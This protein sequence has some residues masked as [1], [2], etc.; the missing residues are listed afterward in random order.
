MRYRDPKFSL[1]FSM[2]I[3][4]LVLVW[5]AAGFG[6]ES[7]TVTIFF[8]PQQLRFERQHGFDLVRLDGAPST[9]RPGEPALP[10]Q[11][12]HI[13]IS[14]G[15]VARSVTVRPVESYELPGTYRLLPGQ[16]PH[17]LDDRPGPP[18]MEPDDAVYTSTAPYPTQLGRLVRQTDLAG[19]Q[20]AVISLFPL[21][22]IPAT[23]RLI[24]HREL[25][26]TVETHPGHVSRERYARFTELQRRVYGDMVRKMVVNPADVRI[27]PPRTETSKSLPAGQF[28]HVIITHSAYASYF[29][30][31]IEWH[32]RRGLR[33][34]VVTTGWIDA[35]YTGD[36]TTRVR[37]FIIDAHS[38]WGTIYFLLGGEE[39]VIPFCYRQ[40]IK[41]GD[42]PDTPPSDNW[43]ADYDD[44]WT[45]E[46]MVGRISAANALEF[47]RIIAKLLK[48]EQ[49]PPMDDYILEALFVGMDYNPT[50]F[51][52]DM[53]EEV[54][55]D[56]P[57]RFTIN[58]VYDSHSGNHLDTVLVHLN[59]G[60]HL[61]NHAD[62]C[63]WWAMGAGAIN[64]GW[65]LERPHVNALT[66][67][68]RF[69][70]VVAEGCW[71]AAMPESDC[72]A[73]HFLF[74][75]VNGGG[76]S[77]CGNTRVG[78]SNATQSMGSSA[79]ERGWWKSL[80]VE[81]L[82]H[83][84]EMVAW[85]KH[86]H[87]Q[88]LTPGDSIWKHCE[89]QFVIAGD[90]AMPLWT[91]TPE[92]FEVA[93]PGT[94]PGG[95]SSFTVHVASGGSDLDSAYVCLWKSGEVYLTGYTDASGQVAFTPVPATAGSLHVTVAKHN[96]LPYRG[97]AQVT[98]S[99][100]PPVTDLSIQ[101]CEDDLVL[102]WTAPGIKTI[103]RYV[104]YRDTDGDFV[105]AEEDSI[106]GTAGTSY[107][108]TGVVGGP[109]TG[110]YYVVKAVSD[111]GGK[112]EPSNC[113][114]ELDVEL[115]TR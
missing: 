105:P 57:P 47:N 78:W 101:L 112:S 41:D 28:D 12:L 49:D 67:T 36:D 24:L 69:S 63:N 3:V 73:E 48:Y 72:M 15:H 66:N 23:G 93:H 13:A 82:Y 4:T 94:L 6:A 90:P 22:Y 20:M 26:I 60:Q 102:A 39:N 33:D 14:A 17:P 11:Q 113:V 84:G 29:D 81:D 76:V 21:Q 58:K 88:D 79:M 83:L 62:H 68:D 111:S 34:T 108:D 89:W 77:F 46:V 38:T 85:A 110:Y 50:M 80:L 51:G 35:N 42:Y 53:K 71:S 32:N 59:A 115:F 9:G 114:G 56:V 44:D 74:H 104:I 5:S 16:P 55:L 27:N 107:I 100:P 19:Q 92:S 86:Q 54:A 2:V 87:D 25:E 1:N 109:S 106:A 99:A 95:S 70:N 103:E 10:V 75:N 43:Y 98:D 40:Y 8:D 31:L 30:D 97:S 91:D 18:F 96:Y 7:T 65:L 61:F 52:E 37:H 45:W 64:H